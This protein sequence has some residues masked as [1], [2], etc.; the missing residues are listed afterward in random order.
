M[1][2]AINPEH[3]VVKGLEEQ[4]H[5][6][7]AIVLIKLNVSEVV[8]TSK[9][10]LALESKFP[11]QMACILAHDKKDGIHLSVISESEARKKGAQ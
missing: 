1:P 4:W 3:P 10:V 7:L 6:L 2:K 9:D 5:K 11:G 8:I